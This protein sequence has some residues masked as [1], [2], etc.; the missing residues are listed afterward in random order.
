MTFRLTT[1]AVVLLWL[2]SACDIGGARSNQGDADLDGAVDHDAEAPGNLI[3]LVSDSHIVVPPGATSTVKVMLLEQGA[4][5]A[6]GAVVQFTMHGRA[7]DSSL[8]QFMTITDV[9]GIAKVDLVAGRVESTF[10]VRVASDGFESIYVPVTVSEGYLGSLTVVPVTEV[11]ASIARYRVQLYG[12]AACDSPRVAERDFDRTA[13]LWVEA[14]KT[15]FL[16]LPVSTE[17][18]VTVE[19]LDAAMEVVALRCVEGVAVDE[20]GAELEVPLL[21]VESSGAYESRL[22]VDLGDAAIAWTTTIG[23]ALDEHFPEETSEAER[24][25]AALEAELA[26]RGETSALSVLESLRS[27]IV[28]GL[29]VALDGRGPV[30]AVRALAFELAHL[31]AMGSDGLLDAGLPSAF[32]FE[33][34]ARFFVDEGGGELVVP[35]SWVWLVSGF[36][37]SPIRATV[38]FTTELSPSIVVID[39]LAALTADG[40]GTSAWLE[41]AAGCAD[42]ASLG[43]LTS[44]GSSCEAE[45]LYGL[46]AALVANAMDAGMSALDEGLDP[47]SKLEVAGTLVFRGATF[48]SQ[49]AQLVTGEAL[50]VAFTGEDADMSAS[51][52][53]ARV[54]SEP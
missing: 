43:T 50:S 31:R 16:Y 13:T 44:L 47:G 26:A 9:N 11:T 23:E 19:A 52:D 10:S 36:F 42:F 22:R 20:D 51:I 24:L 28:L 21:T 14:A 7:N 12:E 54:P 33:E 39:Y 6:Q 49:E 30:T 53:G 45:C 37:D 38:T 5:P 41:E 25:V 18:A 4:L 29:E 2:A 3:L 35:A 34:T 17:Y 46:C 27:S 32:G 1:L 8:G 48:A 15:E 40:G